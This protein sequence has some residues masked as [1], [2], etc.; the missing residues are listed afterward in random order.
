MI[1]STVSLGHCG[2][3]KIAARPCDG[4]PADP[5]F[6]A[7]EDRIGAD[8]GAGR[9]ARVGPEH[10]VIGQRQVGGA[11]RHRTERIE[12]G[13]ERKGPGARQP[14]IGGLQPEQSAQR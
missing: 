2:A 5:V 6:Q 13:D 3:S 10:R 1:D 9:V 14:A 11:A 4:Q 7:G 8:I 12:A